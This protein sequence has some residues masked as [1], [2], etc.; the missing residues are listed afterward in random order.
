MSTTGE[1]KSK[2]SYNGIPL[3]KS[4][5]EMVHLQCVDFMVCKLYSTKPFKK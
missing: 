5:V 4:K 1:F 2:L 3:L